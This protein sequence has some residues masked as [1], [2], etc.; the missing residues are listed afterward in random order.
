MVIRHLS[1]PVTVESY[2]IDPTEEV[3]YIFCSIVT[4]MGYLPLS[5]YSKVFRMLARDV[6]HTSHSFL[7]MA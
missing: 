4:G 5:M 6:P 7:I 3:S 1:N 2:L